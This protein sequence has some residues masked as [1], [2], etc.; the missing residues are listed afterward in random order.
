MRNLEL[1]HSGI[2][3]VPTEEEL[4]ATIVSYILDYQLLSLC[5][6]YERKDDKSGKHTVSF[7]FWVSGLGLKQEEYILLHLQEPSQGLPSVINQLGKIADS[8]GLNF[9]NTF[10]EDGYSIDCQTIQRRI[11]R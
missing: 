7:N 11:S 9:C 5:L 3:F 2:K 6:K 4:E 1:T 8:R 10:A